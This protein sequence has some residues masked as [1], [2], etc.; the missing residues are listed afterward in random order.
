MRSGTG[1]KESRHADGRHQ[2]AWNSKLLHVAITFHPCFTKTSRRRP[3]HANNV[4]AYRSDL[5]VPNRTRTRNSGI[6]RGILIFSSHA[7]G[8]GASGEERKRN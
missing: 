7:R 4:Y 2:N 8:G 3:W 5:C 6:E 1:C